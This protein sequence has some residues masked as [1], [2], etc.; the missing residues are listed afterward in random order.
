MTMASTRKTNNKK[1]T[2]LKL[3]D[4]PEKSNKPKRMPPPRKAICQLIDRAKVQPLKTW[5]KEKDN[6]F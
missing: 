1:I 6:N 2:M 3:P 4:K 5:P